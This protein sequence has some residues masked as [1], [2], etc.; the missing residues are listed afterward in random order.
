MEADFV[1]NVVEEVVWLRRFLQYL[2]IVIDSLPLVT[3]FCNNHVT[4]AYTKDPKYY[5]K[6]KHINI[7]YNL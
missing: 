3:I 1:A 5:I 4:L 6:T 7:K 2:G